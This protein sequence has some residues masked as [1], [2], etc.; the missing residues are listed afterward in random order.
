MSR[1]KKSHEK[2]CQNDKQTLIY[3]EK[4]SVLNFHKQRNAF[5]APVVGFADF[6]CFMERPPE[7]EAKK[8]KICD[9]SG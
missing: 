6:E 9:K 4:G 2:I 1:E 3:P 7:E 8:C 5:K